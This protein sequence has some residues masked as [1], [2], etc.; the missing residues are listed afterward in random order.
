MTTRRGFLESL[1]ALATAPAMA[2]FMPTPVAAAVGPGRY[3]NV[4]DFG[5]VGDGITDDTIAI[6]TAISSS[7]WGTVYFP[8]GTYRMTPTL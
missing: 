8:S 6:Q 7:L 2:G 3:I 1:I 4:R 5:A